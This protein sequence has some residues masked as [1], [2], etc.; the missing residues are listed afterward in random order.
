[1]LNPKFKYNDDVKV[2]L[3]GFYKDCTGCIVDYENNYYCNVITY[4]VDLG[5]KI[6]SFGEGVLELIK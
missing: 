1:M 5:R 4:K 2:L 3:E 6:V